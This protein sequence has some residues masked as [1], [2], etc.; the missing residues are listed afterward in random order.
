MHDLE[1]AHEPTND[2]FLDIFAAHMAHAPVF[3]CRRV[4][5]PPLVVNISLE[6][7]YKGL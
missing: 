7:G 4:P 5:V 2:G 1:N 3:S 6:A